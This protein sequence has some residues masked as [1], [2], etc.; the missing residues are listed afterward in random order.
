MGASALWLLVVKFTADDDGLIAVVRE[1]WYFRNDGDDDNE[2]DDDRDC[3][4]DLGG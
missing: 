3:D 2:A 1:L 4:V